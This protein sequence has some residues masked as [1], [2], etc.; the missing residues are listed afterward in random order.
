MVSTVL[1]EKNG[2]ITEKRFQKLTFIQWV[3]H[4]HEVLQNRKREYKRTDSALEAILQTLESVGILTNP[5]LALKAIDSQKSEKAKR[6]I[7]TGEDPM[8]K[9]YNEMQEKSPATLT[10]KF[11]K[12]E[13]DKFFLPKYDRKKKQLSITMQEAGE[14]E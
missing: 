8:L 2:V 1:Y 11:D 3:F 10:V 12:D 5:E 14:Q 13:K 9:F 6:D 7:E 4:Y